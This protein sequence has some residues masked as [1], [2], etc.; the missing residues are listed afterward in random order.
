MYFSNRFC[1]HH[2]EV[3]NIYLPKEN[4]ISA[5]TLEVRAKDGGSQAEFPSLD[6]VDL[7]AHCSRGGIGT[8]VRFGRAAF[9]Y[10]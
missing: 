9:W 8:P 2:L 7:F 1:L 6:S 10:Y 5:K 4:V 3:S